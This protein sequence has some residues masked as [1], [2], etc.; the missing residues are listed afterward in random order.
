MKRIANAVVKKLAF[1]ESNKGTMLGAAK[2]APCR[3]SNA[4]SRLTA[5][6]HPERQIH[7]WSV[8]FA[9]SFAFPVRAGSGRPAA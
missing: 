5:K 8:S 4:F 6:N 1:P 7:E 2:A 9:A 3:A